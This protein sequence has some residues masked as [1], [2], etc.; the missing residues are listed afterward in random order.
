MEPG[1]EPTPYQSKCYMPPNAEDESTRQLLINRLGVFG[2]SAFDPSEEA[3]A[4]AQA[5]TQLAE[6]LEREDKAPRT[7]QQAWS[8]PSESVAE[9]GLHAK[10]QRQIDNQIRELVPETLEQHPV[11]R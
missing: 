3:A 8:H 7:L 9:I 4:H 10:S 5:R 11:F 6:K 2:K 1:A